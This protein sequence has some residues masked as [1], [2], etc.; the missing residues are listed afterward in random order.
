MRLELR[1]S[2]LAERARPR[3]ADVDQALE[4]AKEPPAAK[5]W[6]AR[7]AELHALADE[8]A[9]AMKADAEAGLEVPSL[10]AW[11]WGDELSP[12]LVRSVR[13]VAQRASEGR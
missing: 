2:R 12:A 5:S 8:L 9:A 4:R 1:L 10:A 3:S 6:K 7:T 11:I 13:D